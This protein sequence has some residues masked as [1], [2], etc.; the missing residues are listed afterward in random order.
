MR[1][2]VCCNV[3]TVAVRAQFFAGAGR[4][5]PCAGDL[6]RDPHP[7]ALRFGLRCLQPGARAFQRPPVSAEQVR[8][9]G[10][11][12]AGIVDCLSCFE[13]RNGANGQRAIFAL[14]ARVHT[15][16]S[17]N[18]GKLLTSSSIAQC[19]RFVDPR[20][21]LADIQVLGQCGVNQSLQFWIAQ[22]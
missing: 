18:R 1:S 7:H 15:G 2:S 22:R 3:A 19:A 10:C 9:P 14:P 4:L 5:E 6:G 16:A 12:E 8:F 21:G 11:V 13:A 17:R 20:G